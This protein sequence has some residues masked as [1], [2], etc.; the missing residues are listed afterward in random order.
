MTGDDSHL[1]DDAL[2]RRYLADRSL[3]ALGPGDE[4]GVRHLADCPSC[5]RR[6][7]VV[8][9]ELDASASLVESRADREFSG[10][11]LTRQ[12]ER[13]LRRIAAHTSVGRVLAFPAAESHSG[14][15]IGNRPALR[16]A[17]AAAIAGLLLGLSAGRWLW[18]SGPADGPSGPRQTPVIGATPGPDRAVVRAVTSD[19]SMPDDDILSQVDF[20]LSAPRTQELQALDAFTLADFDTSRRIR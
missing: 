15:G 8:S 3:D 7:E 4:P 17:A 20:A 12:R 6:Y 19:V 14:F 16:W 1:K 11:Q 9:A 18:T 2:I 5:T 10:E 13:I